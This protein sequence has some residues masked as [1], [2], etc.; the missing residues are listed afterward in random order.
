[1]ENIFGQRKFLL[2]P[3]EALLYRLFKFS[4]LV[5]GSN[6]CEMILEIQRLSC[7]LGV[8]LS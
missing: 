7:Q 8:D 3:F 2:R 6:I 5:T 1:M 4:F